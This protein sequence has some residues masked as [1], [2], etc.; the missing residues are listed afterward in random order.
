M[1]KKYIIPD[2]TCVK[3]VCEELM[4]GSPYDHADSKKFDFDT[5]IEDF[6]NIYPDK[7]QYD[8]WEDEYNF[9]Y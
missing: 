1:K 6:D 2:I 7:R 3:T 4:I 9:D 8:L 5:E